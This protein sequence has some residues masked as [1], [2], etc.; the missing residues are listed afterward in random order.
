MSRKSGYRFS[1]KDMRKVEMPLKPENAGSNPV[2]RSKY[3]RV[4]QLEEHLITNQ[5]ACRFESCRALQFIR[6]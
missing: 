1:D 3:A 2:G 6:V 4:V 5:R